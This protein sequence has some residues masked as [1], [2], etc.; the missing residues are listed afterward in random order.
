MSVSKTDVTSDKRAGKSSEGAGP[1]TRF[2]SPSLWWLSPVTV[3][4]LV[5]GASIVPAAL[6]SDE[7]FRNLWKTPKLVDTE[8]L[9]LF[10][11]GAV[12]MAFGALIAISA[13]PMTRRPTT[14]WPNLNE[15]SVLLLRRASTVLTCLT[16]IG[17][18]GFAALIL[19]AGINPL[20]LLSSSVT[21]GATTLR[22]VVGTIPGVT[23]L[24]QCGVPVVVISTVLLVR[25]F[26]RAE[27][28]K[29]LLVVGLAIPRS[30]IFSERLAMLELLIPIAVIV[31]AQF[32]TGRSRRRGVVRVLPL[33]VL[34]SMIVIFGIF[35]YF[36][37]WTYYRTHVNSS[38]PEFAITRFIGYYA[39]AINNGHL[40]L[41]DMPYTNGVPYYSIEAFWTAPGPKQLGLY[42]SMSGSPPPDSPRHD[43]IY[44]GL[45]K[46]FA[47]P[48]FNNQSGYVG[49]F[50]DY[51]TVGGILYFLIVGVVLGLLYRG[52]RQGSPL[53]VFLYPVV[54]IGL[55]E[56]PRY[57]YWVNGRTICAWVA[58]VVVAVLVSRSETKRTHD[59]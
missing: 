9:V 47:N 24:T 52:F 29:L 56:M 53:G 38:Y 55:L 44:F 48:E 45:L 3:S 36:R 22:D 13:A 6:L 17:Y 18:A 34:P 16:L 33:V 51:G 58:L 54:F 4:L 11:T 26:S 27:L 43:T 20:D 7:K 23:T 10:G 39:T 40:L 28:Y 41:H 42:E 21:Y 50:A 19:R 8:T 30:Y 59:L 46:H 37:S 25:E 5:A 14:P 15:R 32:S 35:E 1:V 49:G 12:A 31:A 57:I 2:V